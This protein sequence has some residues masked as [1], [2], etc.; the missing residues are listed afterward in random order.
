MGTAIAT[1]MIDQIAEAEAH[2]Q[3]AARLGII[4]HHTT[5]WSEVENLI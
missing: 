5:T 1:V 2:T 4:S 3:G